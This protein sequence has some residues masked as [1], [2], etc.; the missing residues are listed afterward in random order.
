MRE[1]YTLTRLFLEGD[2]SQGSEIEFSREQAHYL[3]S[4]LRKAEGESIRVFNGRDGEWRADI[5]AIGKKSGRL[6]VSEILRDQNRVPDMTLL[7][8]P[9]RK[10]R[11]A[12]I[13]EKAT[14]LGVRRLQPVLTQR[15]QFPR[16]NADKARLQAIE[17]AEPVSYTHLPSPRDQRG[18]R[19]PSSA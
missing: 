1:N 4:V 18:S 7:F 11:T 5:A 19:M 2:L 14:E 12:F 10:H 8:A 3:G 15:T 16:F 13:I 17:A 6:T 9:V